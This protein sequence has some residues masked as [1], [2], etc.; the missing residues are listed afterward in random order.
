MIATKLTRQEHWDFHY[1]SRVQ[2]AVEAH[3]LESDR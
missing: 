3:L 2:K 1:F